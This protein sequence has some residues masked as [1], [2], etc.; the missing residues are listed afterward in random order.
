MDQSTI[1]V[2]GLFERLL[3]N[4]NNV[5]SEAESQLLQLT[6]SN[7]FEMIR[8]CSKII[9]SDNI[10]LSAVFYSFVMI[11][12]I[13]TPKRKVTTQLMHE[14]LSQQ[15]PELLENLKQAI[16][17]GLMFDDLRISNKSSE[18]FAKLL[19]VETQAMIQDI[20]KV[21]FLS[22]SSDYPEYIN[23]AAIDTLAQIS[24]KASLGGQTEY[25]IVQQI[26]Q[27]IFMQIGT[28]FLQSVNKSLQYKYNIAHA[29][30]IFLDNAKPLFGDVGIINSLFQ[31]SINVLESIPDNDSSLDSTAVSPDKVH[32][33]ILEEVVAKALINFYDMNFEL[34]I[35]GDYTCHKINEY[36]SKD[37]KTLTNVQKNKLSNLIQFW[38]S[39]SEYERKIN[40]ENNFKN[41][42]MENSKQINFKFTTRIYFPS[43]PKQQRDFSNIAASRIVNSLITILGF[44]NIEDKGSED[45]NYKEPHMFA[46]QCLQNFYKL[47]PQNLF[48]IVQAFWNSK[49]P[50]EQQW[51]YNHSL[52]LTISIITRKP[53]CNVVENFLLSNIAN[54]SVLD[55]FIFGA[56]NSSVLRIVDTTLFSITVLL[57]HY[58]SLLTESRYHRLMEWTDKNKTNPDSIIFV[59]I[60][61]LVSYIIKYSKSAF[62]VRDF[63]DFFEKIYLYGLSRQDSGTEEIYSSLSIMLSN[64]IMKVNR[65]NPPINDVSVIIKF[66]YDE[67]T[68]LLDSS[69]LDSL[70]FLKVQNNISVLNSIFSSQNHPYQDFNDRIIHLYFKILSM[71]NNLFGDAFSGLG[72]IGKMMT[73]SAKYLT[74]NLPH[75][76]D[77]ALTSGSP[78]YITTTT[79]MLGFLY[80]NICSNKIEGYENLYQFLPNTIQLILDCVHKYDFTPEFY[81]RLYKSLAHVMKASQDR[82]RPQTQIV[83]Q[84][85]NEF[86]GFFN[87]PYDFDP[88]SKN[89]IEYINSK[90]EAIFLGGEAIYLCCD[91]NLINDKMFMKK[92]IR[93]WPKQY[94]QYK[95]Y[96]NDYSLFAFILFIKSFN[97]VFGTK[98]NILINHSI[99]T[100]LILYATCSKKPNVSQEAFKTIELIKKA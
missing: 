67:I 83:S 95:E 61:Q 6:D 60:L 29:L 59:R 87:E 2:L 38:I 99:N 98:G 37:H 81:P 65:S 48:E 43:P 36:A 41:L 56:L 39:V 75:F 91:E 94:A 82:L 42:Y 7:L 64:L 86:I 45:T 21:L 51:T 53:A 90:F 26:L 66:L 58:P 92:F 80:Q 84:L 28:L 23:A 5:R 35:I 14:K 97:T 13:L 32:S 33:K 55:D 16:L 1:Q 62:I 25:I 50:L 96:L 30:S 70:I 19:N 4:D 18:A 27:K 78:E 17:R 40:K 68:K 31:V 76:V 71:K 77:I 22:Q 9:L 85:I 88:S 44:I 72:I 69:S 11:C 100:E 10:P 15:P 89:D 54:Y 79:Y 12:N 57:R 47:Y 93:D 20:D 3:S 52:I 24:S 46:T 34:G 8:V 63:R 73:S 74:D 49:D